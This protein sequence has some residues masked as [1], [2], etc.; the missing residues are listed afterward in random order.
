MVV[1]LHHLQLRWFDVAVAW[2]REC[3][4]KKVDGVCGRSRRIKV[5]WV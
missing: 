5:G 1:V 4:G 3:G 2:T